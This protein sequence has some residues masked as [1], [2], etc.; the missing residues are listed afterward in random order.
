MNNTFIT[1][2]KENTFKDITFDEIT[3]ENCD[4]LTKIHKNAFIE[5]EFVTKGLYIKEN[6]LLSSDD[7][8]IFEVF[9]KFINLEELQLEDNN[10]TEI[11]SNAFQRIIGYQDNLRNLSFSGETIK[12]IGSRPFSLLNGLTHLTISN[13]MINYIP[14]DAFE[15][16]EGS[17]QQLTLELYLNHQLNS[18]SFHQDSLTHFKRPVLI[19]LGWP[20][21]Y[22]E[23]LDENIFRKFLSSNPQNKINLVNDLFDCNNCKNLWLKYEPSLLERLVGLSCSN[24]KKF[25]DTG[26]F[27]NCTPFDSIE[28]CTFEKNESTIHRGG[29]TDINL[30]E[31]F[32]KL[33]KRLSN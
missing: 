18:S 25:N 4:N 7:N 5:T 24:K 32:H 16:E 33:S 12:K 17:N 29:K 10:I 13:T 9:S 20:G 1:E 8:S 23:Y 22:F 15:F 2:L 19:N 3:I 27:A 11:P 26:N 30:K 28:P 6:F 21:N 14:E 31:I